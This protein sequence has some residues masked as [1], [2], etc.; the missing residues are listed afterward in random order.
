MPMKSRALNQLLSNRAVA[1]N[2]RVPALNGYHPS[3]KGAIRQ[4]SSVPEFQSHGWQRRQAAFQ[5]SATIVVQL[6]CQSK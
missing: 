4:L 5:A 3:E 2:P 6:Y 1:N